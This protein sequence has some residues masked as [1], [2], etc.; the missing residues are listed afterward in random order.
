M[1]PLSS[2]PSKPSKPKPRKSAKRASKPRLA[3]KVAE[4]GVAPDEPAPPVISVVLLEDNRLLREGLAA[5]IRGEPGFVVLAASADVEEAMEKVR[6]SQ[7]DVVLLDVG[8]EDSDSVELTTRVRAEVPTAKV[9]VMGLLPSEADIAEFVRAGVSGFVMKD[10]TF[11]EFFRTIREVFAGAEILPRELTNT[12]F[13]QIAQNVTRQRRGP[14]LDSIRLTSRERETINLLAEG[15]SNKEIATRLNIAIHTVKSH[16]HNV[17]DKLALRS[18]LEV[19]AFVHGKSTSA[20][21][22]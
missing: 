1:P 4:A 22:Q 11:N 14:I 13:S 5:M 2:H 17:L 9:I 6:S 21:P 20:P 16:V 15:L 12:L 7:A 10:A 19:V 3:K 18:R 8:L